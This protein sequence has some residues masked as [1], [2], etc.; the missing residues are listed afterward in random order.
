MKGVLTLPEKVTLAWMWDHVPVT[1][2]WWIGTILVAV[3]AVGLTLG[4]SEFYWQL[5]GKLPGGAPPAV[6]Q[7]LQQKS[8]GKG[9]P[10]PA[11]SAAE[12]PK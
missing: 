8:P 2:W 11:K 6:S 5:A 3:F 12:V 4:Q 1:W 7:G 9:S 10:I